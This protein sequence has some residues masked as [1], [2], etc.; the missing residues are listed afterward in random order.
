M[1]PETIDRHSKLPYYQQLYEILLGKIQRR[2]WLPGDRIPPESELI[3]E[4]QVSRN[5]VR[6]VFDKLVN[7][8]LIYRQRGR[9]SFRRAP[10]TG[11]IH[12]AHRQLH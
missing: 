1:Y 3:E 12:D 6:Q 4:Y 11:A 9:G 8:G 5:T 10:H 2:E 7:D